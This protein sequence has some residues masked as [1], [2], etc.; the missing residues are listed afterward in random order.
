MSSQGI[1]GGLDVGGHASFGDSGSFVAG[2]AVAFAVAGKSKA[3]APPLLSARFHSRFSV[4]NDDSFQ[5]VRCNQT[6]LIGTQSLE[7]RRWVRKGAS[8]GERGGG[9]MGS[10]RASAARF[11]PPVFL[12]SDQNIFSLDFQIG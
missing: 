1:V 2:D 5:L 8:G 6:F 9:A 7:I 4:R 12:K 11:F 10:R 3:N